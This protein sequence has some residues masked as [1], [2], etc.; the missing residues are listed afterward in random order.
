MGMETS[1]PRA[2]SQLVATTARHSGSYCAAALRVS[3]RDELAEMA[4]S[5]QGKGG[6]ARRRRRRRGEPPSRVPR[7]V[8][9][10]A[11]QSRTSSP[12]SLSNSVAPRVQ[13][14]S[15]AKLGPSCSGMLPPVG[16]T[17]PSGTAPI[18]PSPETFRPCSR[19]P[20]GASGSVPLDVSLKHLTRVV[21][22]ARR[23]LRC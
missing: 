23:L 11:C 15:G 5:S 20:C 4:A 2:G 9:L 6:S 21:L 8:R 13:P 16:L 22:C 18:S 17:Q 10:L 3:S 12:G 7:G 1:A 14:R 19:K